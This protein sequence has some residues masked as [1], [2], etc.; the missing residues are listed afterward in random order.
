MELLQIYGQEKT[1][2]Y[3]LARMNM[4][5]YGVKDTEF[6]SSWRHTRE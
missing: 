6:D 3:N 4:L 5:L 1:H 2:T